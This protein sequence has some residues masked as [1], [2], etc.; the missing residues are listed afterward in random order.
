[1]EKV[2]VLNEAHS[3]VHGDRQASYGHPREDFARTAALASTCFASKLKEPLSAEDVAL[4]MVCVKVSR[5]V[6]GHKR[7]NLVDAAG[8][9]ETLAMLH[10]ES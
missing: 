5:Q 2:S 9:I 6:K 7:D 8:Y 3:L 1:M 10:N 4:F